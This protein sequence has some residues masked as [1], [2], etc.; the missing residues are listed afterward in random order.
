MDKTERAGLVGIERAII[1]EKQS[2][3]AAGYV[4]RVESITR[5]GV[6]SRWMEA[7]SAC[8]R[9]YEVT[10]TEGPAVQRRF[11]YSVGDYVNCFIFGD[12]RGMILGR[13]RMDLD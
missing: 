12:G 13:I 11:E 8:V 5:R 2:D 9:E 10:G 4:Y 7:A 6:E 1:I 3:A